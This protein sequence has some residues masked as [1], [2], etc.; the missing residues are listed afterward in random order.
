MTLSDVRKNIDRVDKE[1][2]QLFKERMM[3]ADNVARVKAETDDDIYKPDREETIIANLTGDVDDD[4][5]ME[6]TA[7]I[8]R[9][10][11]ISRKY[12]Y[13][14][15]LELRNC[16]NVD[17]EEN[18][19]EIDA[20]AMIKPELY[21]CQGCSRDKVVAVDSYDDVYEL[22]KSGKV[23]AGMG[24]LEDISYGVSEHPDSLQQEKVYQEVLLFCLPQ[25]F[26]GR[27][28][29]THCPRLQSLHVSLPDSAYRYHHTIRPLLLLSKGAHTLPLH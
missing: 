10:M 5:K 29:V 23:D 28:P 21:I 4:I 14:R 9:I 26:Q 15:T 8:K 6:Y 25:V 17:Y 20:V 2:K 11:E 12:Q 27:F 7:L 13:G 22:I 3:L 19:P 24:I 16:L 1:I 18:E